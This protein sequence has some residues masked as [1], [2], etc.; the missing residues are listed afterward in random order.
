LIFG[1]APENSRTFTLFLKATFS[2][3]SGEADILA[4]R[5]WFGLLLGGKNAVK[6]KSLLGKNRM[7]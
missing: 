6:I 1:L 7:L 3:N 2:R 4:R 5:E